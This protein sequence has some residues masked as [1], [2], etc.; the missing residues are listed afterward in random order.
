MRN[1]SQ[2]NLT[3]VP[4]F[5][6]LVMTSLFAILWA[7]WSQPHTIALRNSLLTVGSLMGLYVMVQH[8]SILKSRSAWPIYLVGA[9]L[10]WI[11]FH[12]FFLSHQY[13]LQ[14]Q[15]FFTIWKRIVWAAPFAIGLGCVLG[16]ATNSAGST[17]SHSKA[18]AYLGYPLEWWIFYLGV[19][20]PTLSYL[21]RSLLMFMAQQSAWHLPEFAMH[22]PMT[23]TWHIPKMAVVFYCIPAL[24]IACSQCV[25]LG[26]Q[27]SPQNWILGAIY[28]ASIAAVLAVFYLENAK[29]GMAYSVVLIVVML[30]NIAIRKKT[31]WSWREGVIIALSILAMTFVL[32]QHIERSREWKTL[33]ADIKV[34]YLDQSDAWKDYGARGYPVNELGTIVSETNYTR[35][36]WAKV[37]VGMIGQMPQGYGL[38]FTSF[39]HLAKEKWPISTVV[40]C[41]SAWLDLTLGIGIPGV[42]LLIFAGA[43]ALKNAHMAAPRP[44]G[45][46]AAWILLSIALLM[47]TTEVS[48]SPYFETLVFIVLWVAGIG[49]NKPTASKTPN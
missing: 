11:T 33:F 18:S 17:S 27:K 2:S 22:M 42:L 49:L 16:Q 35:A 39:G 28:G 29:N 38:V 32:Q 14:L 6:S 37:A 43:L 41:H 44:W 47:I 12:L 15:E 30:I 46:A 31:R 24:A 3:P 1:Y 34:A 13:Q 23:S 26:N 9:L 48:H 40:Q 20:S 36:A 4:R 7:V 45:Q 10:A 25:R 21:T 8:W 19:M 5:V